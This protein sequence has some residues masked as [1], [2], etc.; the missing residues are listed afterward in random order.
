MK[1]KF[2]FIFCILFLISA[3]NLK[4]I[5][6]ITYQ[7][8]G[9]AIEEVDKNFDV[10]TANLDE[11]S[12]NKARETFDKINIKYQSVTELVMYAWEIQD[13][14]IAQKDNLTVENLVKEE[15]QI[16][17]RYTKILLEISSL[18]SEIYSK[19]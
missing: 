2:A 16:I 14:I 15:S 4:T 18:I 12:K 8:I 13:M 11:E 6:I 1:P 5:S 7:T 3:C 10:L 9:V 19:K 17:A